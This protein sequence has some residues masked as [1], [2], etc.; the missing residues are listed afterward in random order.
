MITLYSDYILMSFPKVPIA[1]GKLPL[2]HAAIL[3]K[4]EHSPT[5]FNSRHVYH[6]SKRNI[7]R[8]LNRNCFP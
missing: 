7:P 6:V 3:Q 4:Y 2:K 8:K 1:I 5:L